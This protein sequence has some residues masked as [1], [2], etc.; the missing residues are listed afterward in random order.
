V[1]N[2]N[3]Q[4]NPY[5]SVNPTRA[6]LTSK[7]SKLDIA[8]IEY[9]FVDLDPRH[10]ERSEDAKARY[11]AG[12]G[13][14][15]PAPTVIIDSGNGIQALW[16]LDQPIALPAPITVEGPQPGQPRRVYSAETQAAIDD[17]EGRV[18]A[19]METLN[20]IAGTQNVDRSRVMQRTEYTEI[21]RRIGQSARTFGVRPSM[22]H[23]DK[24][25]EGD[26]YD[27]AR[28]RRERDRSQPLARGNEDQHTGYVE[29]V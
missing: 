23:R 1:L 8:A 14:F 19:L 18:K 5:F 3:G 21:A 29:R 17:A 6:A 2:N 28:D 24:R 27:R 16:R 12:L 20:S 10:D 15:E 13:T 26:P 9:S 25:S 11:L 7:A 22:R 4:K